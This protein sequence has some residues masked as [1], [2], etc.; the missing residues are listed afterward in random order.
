MWPIHYR[1]APQERKNNNKVRKSGMKN[2]S[3]SYAGSV[4]GRMGVL[5]VEWG[6]WRLNGGVGV[7]TGLFVIVRGR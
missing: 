3:D 4:G 7:R 6:C 2:C 5:V 1:P